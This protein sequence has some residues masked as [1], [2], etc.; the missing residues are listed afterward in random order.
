MVYEPGGVATKMMG[1]ENP[2]AEPG[3]L[4]PTVAAEVGF[5][6]LGIRQLTRGAFVHE[7]AAWI[8]SSLPVRLVQAIGIKA[9]TDHLKKLRAE[10]A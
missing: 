6:D 2:K 7:M 5:R 3:M 1:Q 8:G 9:S 10:Q 4:T